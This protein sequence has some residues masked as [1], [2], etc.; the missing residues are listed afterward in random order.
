MQAGTHAGRQACTGHQAS[1]TCCCVPCKRVAVSY[2]RRVSTRLRRPRLQAEVEAVEGEN[3]FLSR[4]L[5]RGG[6]QV[7]A[8]SACMHGAL[9]C[10]ERLHA[11]N[12]CMHGTL[13]RMQA[14]P[15][16]ELSCMWEAG[17]ACARAFAVG[18]CGGPSRRPA[19]HPARKQAN[20]TRTLC[21][22]QA[23]A[24]AALGARVVGRVAA[25]RTAEA[26]M[27]ERVTEL[28]GCGGGWL[29]M[30]VHVWRV[31][32]AWRVA[33]H[34]YTSTCSAGGCTRGVRAR[35]F[36]RSVL[37]TCAFDRTSQLG[38]GAVQRPGSAHRGMRRAAGEEGGGEIRAD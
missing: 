18:L 23:G 38:G 2:R 27:G 34:A 19:M 31:S 36:S 29:C 26:A 21:C 25:R 33:G 9:A 16:C 10:M 37:C 4:T 30:R 12:A 17:E 11:W 13:A 3:G 1:L 28:G 24:L 22:L 20:S 8:W 6:C 32:V 15:L 35:R 5:E 14:W 7:G